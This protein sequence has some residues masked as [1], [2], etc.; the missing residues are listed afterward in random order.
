MHPE[1]PRTPLWRKVFF[2]LFDD[3]KQ[4]ARGGKL[5]KYRDIWE[6]NDEYKSDNAL[7]EFRRF[8]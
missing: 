8:Y 6:L 7:R 3:H 4:L 1:S 2:A 5:L